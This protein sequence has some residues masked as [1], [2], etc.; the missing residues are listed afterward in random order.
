[1]HAE[2]IATGTTVVINI[3][4][5][6]NK[7]VSTTGFSAAT[8]VVSG[9]DR[10]TVTLAPSVKNQLKGDLRKVAVKGAAITIK[11]VRS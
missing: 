10:E 7:P 2:L 8:L 3:F 11:S 1:M 9:S 4:D 6:G 5:E